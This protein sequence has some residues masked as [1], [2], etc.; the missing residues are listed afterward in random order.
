[1]LYISS[2][3]T[4]DNTEHDIREYVKAY[5]FIDLV[6]SNLIFFFF[7][8]IFLFREIG[9]GRIKGITADEVEYVYFFFSNKIQ[10]V[11]NFVSFDFFLCSSKSVSELFDM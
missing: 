6:F 4:K 3:Q 1:M 2:G 10:F 7:D 5:V 8:I 9:F 11:I